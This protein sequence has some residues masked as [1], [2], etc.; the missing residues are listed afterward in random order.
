MEGATLV[1]YSGHAEG[2]YGD[3]CWNGGY[4][5]AHLF[6][7]HLL[8]RI[9]DGDLKTLFSLFGRIV[10]HEGGKWSEQISVDK[11]IQL[12]K[13]FEFVGNDSSVVTEEVIHSMNGFL[14]DDRL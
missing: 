14:V 13:G 1:D 4:G 9:A 10:K 7:F 5:E 12:R 8:K 3:C 6:A 2:V 11:R